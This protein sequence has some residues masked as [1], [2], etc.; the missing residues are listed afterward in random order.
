MVKLT[1]FEFVTLKVTRGKFAKLVEFAKTL[2]LTLNR[3]MRMSKDMI[4]DQIPRIYEMFV[5]GKS[6]RFG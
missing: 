2:R 5:I 4:E 3:M 6:G 1:N